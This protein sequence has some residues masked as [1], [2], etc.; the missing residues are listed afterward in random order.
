VSTYDEAAAGTYDAEH[1][2][3]SAEAEAV[4]LALAE[5]A[6]RGPALELGIGTGRVAL[7]L[8]ALGVEVHGVD[9]S[10]AM[11]ARLRAK[12]GGDGVAVGVGDFADVGSLVEPGYRLVFVVYNTF[13]ELGSQDEQVR[14]FEGVASVLVPGGI[15]VV[16]ALVP[17]VTTLEASI[18][19]APVGP[20]SV[21]LEAARHDP[22]TQRV[23]LVTTTLTVTGTRVRSTRL[24]Y[25][26]VPE[27][28]LMARLAGLRLRERWG[29]WQGQPF[30]SASQTH[31]SVYER[32]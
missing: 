10:E 1:P 13:F 31:V 7:P 22:A 12:P 8:A 29:G 15:F 17:D 14:C 19:S 27:L 16:E 9:A 23:D 30:T 11:L 2:W 18:S 32:P 25:A 28:D 3:R 6:G 21:R 4:A 24:R 26:T 5:L 20:D